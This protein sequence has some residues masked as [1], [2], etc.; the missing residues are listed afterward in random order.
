MV[1]ESDGELLDCE[2]Q[3]ATLATSLSLVPQLS[4]ISYAS[5]I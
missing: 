2:F 1:E 4:V 3:I 5:F